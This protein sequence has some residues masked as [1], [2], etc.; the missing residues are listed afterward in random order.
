LASDGK[1]YILANSVLA[2]PEY[3]SGTKL[4][5]INQPNVA[6]RACQIDPLLIDL[7]PP[8]RPNSVTFP[9]LVSSFLYPG[10]QIGSASLCPANVFSFWIA[11]EGRSVPAD[12]L[13]EAEWNFGDVASPQNQVA[14]FAPTHAYSREGIYTASVRVTWMD[15]MQRTYTKKILVGSTLTV[16]LGKDTVLCQGQTLPLDVSASGG[17]MRWQDGSTKAGYNVSKAGLYWVQVCKNGCSV[18]DTIRVDFAEPPQLNLED[19]IL[20]CDARPLTLAVKAPFSRIHWSN[21]ITT[22]QITVAQ[23]GR[24]WVS[25]N[26]PCGVFTDTVQVTYENGPT[27]NL[28]NDTTLCV[29]QTLRLNAAHPQ[30]RQYFWQGWA[31]KAV[32]DV[33]TDGD[34]VVRVQGVLCSVAD[35]I[36]VRFVECES[37]L[38]IP[39]VFTPNG[40]GVNETFEVKG[41]LPGKWRLVVVNRFGQEVYQHPGYT[42]DW[43]G[44]EL[45]AGVYYYQLQDRDTPRRYKGWVQIMR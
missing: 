32:Y 3:T 33:S 42:N 45:P 13:L 25:V 23:S 11:N 16:N 44:H 38:V 12:T 30:G 39:N 21:G 8:D 37:D 2:F 22:N 14:G 29:G 40:D 28:G 26:S 41:I 35:T 4:A 15:G 36:S 17:L 24:Y 20:I 43:N 18:S 34:Y 27:V 5:G 1:I 6:G 7:G 31:G 9:N 19:S 10:A